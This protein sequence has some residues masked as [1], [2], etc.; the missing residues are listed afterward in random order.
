M[1]AWE[2]VARRR[3]ERTPSRHHPQAPPADRPQPSGR[4]RFVSARPP[5]AHRQRCPRLPRRS[6]DVRTALGHRMRTHGRGDQLSDRRQGLGVPQ[7]ARYER[8]PRHGVAAT[9]R[10][11]RSGLD[12]GSPILRLAAQRRG[13]TARWNH[14]DV[15]AAN[16]VRRG[17]VARRTNELESLIEQGIARSNFTVPTLWAHA[18]RLCRHG[19]PG[20]ARFVEV[21]SRR[22]VWRRP[23]DS[24]YELRLERAMRAA[25]FLRSHASIPCGSHRESPCTQISASRRRLLHR[26]G[27]PLVA[28]R[29]TRDGVRPSA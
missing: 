10:C 12:R 15:A 19:R 1:P 18:R 3:A 27:P 11:C 29:A 4:R 16:R 13:A 6:G 26:G 22:E 23:V 5:R 8:G 2:S 17:R 25:G 9:N 28:R 20:S 24:D 21:L 7:D 14:G